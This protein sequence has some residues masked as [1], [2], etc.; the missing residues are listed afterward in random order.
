M[1]DTTQ[2]LIHELALVAR[3]LGLLSTSIESTRAQK[4]LLFSV[5]TLGTVEQR[6]VDLEFL[7]RSKDI[8]LETLQAELDRLRR[9]GATRTEDFGA[10]FRAT[11]SAIA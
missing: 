2:T 11:G 7:I 5:E 1:L 6:V 9:A 4:A 3:A 10:S 8:E